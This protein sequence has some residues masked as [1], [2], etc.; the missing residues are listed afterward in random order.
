[1]NAKKYRAE[2]IRLK[3]PESEAP[4]DEGIQAAGRFFRI[5]ERTARKWAAEGPPPMVDLFFE[6]MDALNMDADDMR[7]LLK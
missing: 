4:N 3:F 1:M 2:L 7:E 5:N 6:I